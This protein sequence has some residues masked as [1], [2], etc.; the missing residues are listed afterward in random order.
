[1]WLN[2]TLS[3]CSSLQNVLVYL[4]WVCAGIW[5]MKEQKCCW[6]HHK[7]FTDKPDCLGAVNSAESLY[8][9]WNVVLC[10]KHSTS[11]VKYFTQASG[12]LHVV[13]SIDPCGIQN[14]SRTVWKQKGNLPIFLTI[15][16]LY[17]MVYLLLYRKVCV[18]EEE[19]IYLHY[20]L[21]LDSLFSCCPST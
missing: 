20:Q 4:G 12:V 7:H 19:E 14:V 13:C 8:R 21:F 17:Y 18:E 15:V 11:E 3:V 2:W 16:C 6:K 9:P 10:H 1:M 5:E